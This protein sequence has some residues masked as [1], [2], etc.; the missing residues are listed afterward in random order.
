MKSWF[1]SLKYLV[2]FV[3]AITLSIIYL[4]TLLSLNIS[5]ITLSKHEGIDKIAER[6]LRSN[7]LQMFSI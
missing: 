1:A 6:A 5:R 3:L 2:E 4:C 7:I